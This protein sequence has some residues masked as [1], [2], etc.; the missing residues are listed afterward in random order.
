M[1]SLRCRVGT[2]A[3]CRGLPIFWGSRLW[4]WFWMWQCPPCHHPI[5]VPSTAH[6]TSLERAKGPFTP[7]GN[8]INAK[9]VCCHSFNKS[10]VPRDWFRVVVHSFL[11]K[12]PKLATRKSPRKSPNKLGVSDT[13]KKITNEY[14]QKR[15][16]KIWLI[17]TTERFIQSVEKHPVLYDVTMSNYKNNV[18]QATARAVIGREF[19]IGPDDV[20]KKWKQLKDT[21]RIEK[22]RLNEED[23]S[24]S[25]LDG[26]K[27]AKKCWTYYDQMGFL[28][29]VYD[30]AERVT[31]VDDD[32]DEGKRSESFDEE[33]DSDHHDE[34]NTTSSLIDLDS[35]TDLSDDHSL[36]EMDVIASGSCNKDIEVLKE[37]GFKTPISPAAS[38]TAPR[39]TKGKKAS[40]EGETAKEIGQLMKTIGQV[41]ESK[42]EVN[43]KPIPLERILNK[44]EEEWLSYGKNLGLRVA[45]IDDKETRDNIRHEIEQAIYHNKQEL[46]KKKNA[47][48]TVQGDQ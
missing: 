24:G 35:T 13:S 6:G 29:K 31:N 30:A 10:C 44:I 47:V 23:P 46:K 34:D 19:S 40:L 9:S 4:D 20:K 17:T 12:M 25:G 36:K 5:A 11:K 37:P 18:S 8:I 16:R 48:V 28:S 38:P 45:A 2:V 21:Y 39:K 1:T 14:S 42:P 15:A 22:K 41:L 43:K 3:T 27:R 32:D 26:S 33:Q 7:E